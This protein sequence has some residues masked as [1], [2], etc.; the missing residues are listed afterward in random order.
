MTL[1]GSGTETVTT[2]SYFTPHATVSLAGAS[3]PVAIADASGRITFKVDLGRGHRD[4]QYTSQARLAG[5]DRA[6]YFTTHAVRFVP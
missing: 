2:A 6:G 5:E 1:S 3:E 4:Q